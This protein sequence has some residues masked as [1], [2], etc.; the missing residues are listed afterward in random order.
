M[1]NTVLFFGKG[2]TNRFLFVLFMFCLYFKDE[3]E[4]YE[5]QEEYEFSNQEK[6][7]IIVW[8]AF[9]PSNYLL[10]NTFYLLEYRVLHFGPS[11]SRNTFMFGSLRATKWMFKLYRH[12]EPSCWN[13]WKIRP[14]FQSCSR[15]HFASNCYVETHFM[16][17]QRH[18][19]CI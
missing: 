16:F 4:L 14:L 9:F 7:W 2:A 6:F 18:L 11:S 1:Q 19:C 13:R 5:K 3:Y 10:W 15:F 17:K 8:L 12:I